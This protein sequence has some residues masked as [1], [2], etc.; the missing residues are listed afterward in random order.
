[1]ASQLSGWDKIKKR[2]RKEAQREK[3]SSKIPK[4]S[5][6]FLVQASVQSSVT[7]VVESASP[8]SQ[9]N[10]SEPV[11]TR[12]NKDRESS[13]ERKM[14]KEVIV[15]GFESDSEPETSLQTPS[16]QPNDFG[17][18]GGINSAVRECWVKKSSKD[19]Q[20]IESTFQKSARQYS[21][22]SFQ[23][24]CTTNFFVCTHLLYGENLIG[25]GCAT[26]LRQESCSTLHASCSVELK[27]K[28]PNLFLT[29]LITGG[30]ANPE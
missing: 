30:Q 12:E 5:S 22:E 28:Q 2:K 6:F 20:H 9:N 17:Q 4:L 16:D 18:W 15:T 29:D 11:K 24:R 10:Q 14:E 27:F 25:N 3:L 13:A 26:R 21:D 7:G 19:C 23:R 1:M 8:E